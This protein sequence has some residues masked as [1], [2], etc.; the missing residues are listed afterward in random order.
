MISVETTCTR[1]S[2]VLPDVFLSAKRE[3]VLPVAVCV[4]KL[5][6]SL[7]LLP[8]HS[9]YLFTPIISLFLLP[10]H[11]YDLFIP[12]TSLLLLSLY[13]YY[14]FIVLHLLILLSA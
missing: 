3:F 12:F 8:L 2:Y 1:H 5:Y 14:P 7:F 10:L 11:S 4:M 6:T 9:Y 13:S